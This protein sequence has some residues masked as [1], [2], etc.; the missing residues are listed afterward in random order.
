[1]RILL[2][3]LTLAQKALSVNLESAFLTVTICR[4]MNQG[5]G[6]QRTFANI[7]RDHF[8]TLTNPNSVLYNGFG[9][10]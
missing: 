9:V 2:C 6:C 7:F 8:F 5:P 10:G 4:L 3:L 1:M